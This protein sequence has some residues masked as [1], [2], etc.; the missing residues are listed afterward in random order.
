MHLAA[1]SYSTELNNSFFVSFSCPIKFSGLPMV[2]GAQE[3]WVLRLRVILALVGQNKGQ[4]ENQ[5]VPGSWWEDYKAEIILA[6][7]PK[8]REMY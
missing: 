7:T 3:A 6:M 2:W 1:Q 5:L 8:E 4:V